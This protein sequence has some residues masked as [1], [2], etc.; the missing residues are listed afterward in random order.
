MPTLKHL[1]EDLKLIGSHPDRVRIPGTLYDEL[2][3]QAE[4]D[5]DRAT[6]PT[7]D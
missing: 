5:E 7:D 6:N 1:L 3:E 2:V 4:E